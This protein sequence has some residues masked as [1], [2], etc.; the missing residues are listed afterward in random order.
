MYIYIYMTDKEMGTWRVG[1][2]KAASSSGR[3]K[4][5]GEAEREEEDGRSK[6]HDVIFGVV[7]NF[8]LI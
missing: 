4:K 1:T 2:V 8:N 6:L 5:R 3:T 7:K